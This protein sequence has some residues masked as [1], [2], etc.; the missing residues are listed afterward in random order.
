L[1]LWGCGWA[2]EIT[3][4]VSQAGNDER[5]GRNELDAVATIQRAVKLAEAV[6]PDTTQVKIVLFPGLYLAQRFETAGHSDQ[7][8]IVI[9][10][11]EGGRAVFDGNGRGNTWMTIRQGASRP[12]HITIDSV[13]VRNYVTAISVAGD[14]D[15]SAHWAGGLVIRNNKFSHIGDIAH[16]GAK[17]STAAIRLVNSDHNVIARNVFTHIRNNKSCELLHAIYVAHGS[18]DNLIEGNEFNNSCGDSIRF[19]DG[20]NNNVVRNNSFIDSWARSP[21]SDWFC[22]KDR[23]SDCT[24]V[25]GECPSVN[26]LVEDNRVISRDLPL[27]V[28]FFSW[29]GE[30]PVG[31]TTGSRV[32]IK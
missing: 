10:S 5:K 6:S 12:V 23:R 30:R 19:R 2:T 9:T 28:I 17:P 8:P 24:K 15:N 29:G 27:T 31:C 11:G 1:S 22:N 32:I 20:S 25:A 26:N 21:I 16:S 4:Y 14:R 18:T 13:D 7:V 3:I